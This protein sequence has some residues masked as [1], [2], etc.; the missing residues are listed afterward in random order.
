MGL[1]SG[2]KMICSSADG[3]GA[4]GAIMY[5]TGRQGEVTV[6][7]GAR[8]IEGLTSSVAWLRAGGEDLTPQSG[9]T[10]ELGEGPANDRSVLPRYQVLSQGYEGS[11]SLQ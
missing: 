3:G 6:N 10:Q 8:E 4:A 9:S 5:G 2:A 11:R 7:G 1:L